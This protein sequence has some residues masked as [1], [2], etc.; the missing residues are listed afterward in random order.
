MKTRTEYTEEQRER[1]LYILTEELGADYDEAVDLIDSD[2]E[3]ALW[4]AREA[5]E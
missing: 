5:A 4:M 2:F 1:V 3:T